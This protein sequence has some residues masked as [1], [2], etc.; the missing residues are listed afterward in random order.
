M[1]CPH[2]S[3]LIQD[4]SASLCMECG[5]VIDTDDLKPR[6]YPWVLLYTTNTLLDAEMYKA[7]LVSAGIP[8]QIL[9]QVDT[10]R[11]FT[12]GDLAIVKI[13]VQEPYYKH[14][15]EIINEINNQS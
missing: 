1:L 14:A 4:E 2:C 8:T 10:T 5:N 13:F 12:V 7:N 6:K 3:A 15:K 9:S 11:F